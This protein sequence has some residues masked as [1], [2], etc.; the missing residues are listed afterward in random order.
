MY[1]I[2]VTSGWKSGRLSQC[3][4][5]EE[6][7][8][9]AFHQCLPL[10]EG[11]RGMGSVHSLL[12]SCAEISTQEMICLFLCV[13]IHTG[14]E[15]E[16]CQAVLLQPHVPLPPLIIMRLTAKPLMHKNNRHHIYFFKDIFWGK[17]QLRALQ[18]NHR[19]AE[20]M[21]TKR[22]GDSSVDLTYS[23]CVELC[24]HT[25]EEFVLIH[26]TQVQSGG[27]DANGD[28]DIFHDTSLT[29]CD[30]YMFK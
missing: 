27:E 12:V 21:E 2:F 25:L 16:R 3:E 29:L 30:T 9:R 13:F 8:S 23:Q 1:L 11:G 18:Q 4:P 22:T 15:L 5:Q 19:D 24:V 17:C 6:W 14:S 10:E 26:C 20:N 28:M 7:W